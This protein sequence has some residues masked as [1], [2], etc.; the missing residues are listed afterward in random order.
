MND[1]EAEKALD[2]LLGQALRLEDRPPDLAFAARVDAAVAEAERYRRW[3]AGMMRQLAG[4]LLALAGLT[5][6]VAVLAHAP[7]VGEALAGA[8]GLVWPALL[9][10]LLLWMTLIRGPSRLFG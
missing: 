10:L 3:R 5:G 2:V 7:G 6:G 9:S 8:P 4:E 1:V